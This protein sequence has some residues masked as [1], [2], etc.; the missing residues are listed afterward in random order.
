MSDPAQELTY[1]AKT[2]QVA[3]IDGR[4]LLIV[5]DGQIQ[6]KTAGNNNLSIIHF[7]TYSLDAATFT[8]GADKVTLGPQEQSTLSLLTPDPTDPV[9][10]RAPERFNRELHRRFV[11][12]LFAPLMVAVALF[13]TARARS[14]RRESGEA[15]VL[16]A[17]MGFALR[18]VGY[19]LGSLSAQGGLLAALGYI[20]PIAAFAILIR[21]TLMDLRF[22]ALGR[23]RT[24]IDHLVDALMSRLPTLRR[25]A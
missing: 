2:G 16:A 1:I 19:V 3:T 8:D 7:A 10:Q 9:Y 24:R 15:M 5:S 21:L 18:G 11:E 23:V 25:P 6:R 12:P 20:I 14:N 13:F 22:A 4:T 17:L